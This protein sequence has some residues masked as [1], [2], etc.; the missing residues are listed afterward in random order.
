MMSLKKLLLASLF[1]GSILSI[2]TALAGIWDYSGELGPHHWANIESDYSEC[3]F[4]KEQSPIDIFHSHHTSAVPLV[5]QFADANSNFSVNNGVLTQTYSQADGLANTLSYQNDNYQ[6]ININFH[7]PAEHEILGR[8]SAMEVQLFYRD[9][10][11]HLAI[12]SVLVNLTR[13][14]R[15]ENPLLHQI[16]QALPVAGINSNMA[17]INAQGF[18][19]SSTAN[20]Q[21]EGS[22]TYPP[23]IEGVQ[24]VIY[25]QA[26]EITYS[27]LKAFKQSMTTP[28]NRPIQ[29]VYGREVLLSE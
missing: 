6:L 27:D 25:K 8:R 11:G 19:P 13:H 7:V 28:N 17:S 20:Y 18:L 15:Y 23:C 5:F 26:I 22:L 4:G 12:V 3:S 21:Y 24:W 14:D 1:T 2:N 9:S 10:D 16:A 29:P